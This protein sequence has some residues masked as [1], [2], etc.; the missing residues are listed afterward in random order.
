MEPLRNLAREARAR[1]QAKEAHAKE[2]LEKVQRAFER[3]LAQA[4][5]DWGDYFD[6]HQDQLCQVRDEACAG[7]QQVDQLAA[8]YVFVAHA[9]EYRRVV[10]A[11][12]RLEPL[13]A[14]LR[15]ALILHYGPH[16]RAALQACEAR[17]MV[18]V[19]KW[20]D[21]FRSARRRLASL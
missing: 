1:I 17:V 2:Q 14:N 16:T 19:T 20:A 10:R 8:Q 18:M 3:D 6:L 13:S 5:G 7:L 4:E 12:T 15:K 21:F 11:P 9:L